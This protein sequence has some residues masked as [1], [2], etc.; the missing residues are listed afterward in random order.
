[1]ITTIIG[2]FLFFYVQDN[3]CFERRARTPSP[4]Y[5]PFRPWESEPGLDLPPP[6]VA[7]PPPPQK[8]FNFC[9]HWQK[10]HTRSV[11]RVD[12]TIEYI[13]E[14]E[15]P[16]QTRPDHWYGTLH[17]AAIADDV[18]GIKQLL[19][20]ENHKRFLDGYDLEGQTP[21]QA[22][23]D[24]SS[25]NAIDYLI[26]QAAGA[27][28]SNRDGEYTAWTLAQAYAELVGHTNVVPLMALSHALAQT[29]KLQNFELKKRKKA[30]K[31]KKPTFI[32]PILSHKIRLRRRAPIVHS[33]EREDQE[34]DEYLL[35]V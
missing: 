30:Y 13:I 24:Y 1:M 18:K 19:E 5:R 11:A 7:P 31:E 10:K 9:E 20:H 34:Y 28:T 15:K 25:V 23:V 32:K 8:E 4:H 16:I 27:G 2:V 26:R 14:K 21:L 33:P 35:N 22:A 17:E 3:S 12:G 6:L 29:G